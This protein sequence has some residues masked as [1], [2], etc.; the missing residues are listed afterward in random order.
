MKQLLMIPVLSTLMLA[1]GNETV[2][3]A[4]QQVQDKPNLD[5][6]YV[7]TPQPIVDE[8]L[9]LANVQKDEMVY[10]LGCGDG[11]IVITAAQKYGAKG[12]GV[13][14]DPERIADSNKNA[15]TANVTD[16]VKFV[17]GDLF[18]MDFK[19][20]DVLMMYLLPEVNLRLRPKIL[21]DL[22]PGTRVVSH[23]FDMKEWEPDERS[24]PMGARVYLWI[25]PAKL[26]GTWVWDDSGTARELVLTQEFQKVNGTLGGAAI[27]NAKLKGADLEFQVTQDGV[28]KT[29]KGKVARPGEIEGTVGA[30]ETNTPW[31]AKLKAK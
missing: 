9:R 24:N 1:C 23:A 22:K 27:A 11:R 29:Y 20:A 6:P 16:K 26:E 17:Q 13:D 5:V 19:D 12:I 2:G 14:L 21:N 28:T 18:K 31:T 10:D 30:G 8:M 25:V 3:T 7:P 15:Q 4:A